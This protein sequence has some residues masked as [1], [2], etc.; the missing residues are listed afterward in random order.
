MKI[1]K[2]ID[3]ETLEVKYIGI[4][5][6]ELWQRLVSHIVIT[7]HEFHNKDKKSIWIRNL[8]IM[9]KI[10][11]IKLIKE[12]DNNKSHLEYYY[13]RK[14][15][16]KGHKLLNIKLVKPRKRSISFTNKRELYLKSVAKIIKTEYTYPKLSPDYI[17]AIRELSSK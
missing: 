16:N 14:Y 11:I 13:I 5:S 9:G 2:L 15:L 1:Y 3:P 10:P 8:L 12:V 6:R 7:T 17:E 4:T